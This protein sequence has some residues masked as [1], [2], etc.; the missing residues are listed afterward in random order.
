METSFE[1]GAF[2]YPKDCIIRVLKICYTGDK[3]NFGE[4]RHYRAD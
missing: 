2:Y 1:C 3:L 4:D